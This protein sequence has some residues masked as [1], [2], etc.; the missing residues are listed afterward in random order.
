MELMKHHFQALG[1]FEYR[2]AAAGREFELRKAIESKYARALSTASW[3]KRQR[4]QL[5]MWREFIQ[6]RRRIHNPSP[7][8][9]W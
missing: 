1:E 2:R 3:L 6:S 9:L 5:Q 4:I 8:T 7:H